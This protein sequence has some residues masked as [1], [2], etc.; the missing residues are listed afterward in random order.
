MLDFETLMVD[1]KVPTPCWVGIGFG[2]SDMTNV[3]MH[4]AEFKN[5]TDFGLIDMYSKTKGRPIVDEALEGTNDLT[6]AQ[7]SYKDNMYSLSYNRKLKTDDKYDFIMPLVFKL[8]KNVL[9]RMKSLKS[10]YHAVKKIHF[11]TM[12]RRYI[13]KRVYFYRMIMLRR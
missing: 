5:K 9:F 10:L 3:D 1:I 2:T 12:E 7:Y 6:N 4:V 11:H 8:N 13:I